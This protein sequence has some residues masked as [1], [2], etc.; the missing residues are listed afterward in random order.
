MSSGE[1][2]G[3]I[4]ITLL[5][6]SACSFALSA[7]KTILPLAAPGLAGKPILEI[8]VACLSDCSSKLGCNN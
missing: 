3:L 4:K 1:V 6:F 8:V 5:P 7:E 2:S